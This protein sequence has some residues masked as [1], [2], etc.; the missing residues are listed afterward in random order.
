MRERISNQEY[1]RFIEDFDW[2]PGKFI[3]DDYSF[4]YKVDNLRPNII[5]IVPEII[6]SIDDFV[7]KAE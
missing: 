4:L 7:D 1:I 2:H 3:P 6:G 5:E